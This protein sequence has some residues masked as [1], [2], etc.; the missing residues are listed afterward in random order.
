MRTCGDTP[1]ILRDN[2]QISIGDTMLRFVA[3]VGPEEQRPV[4]QKPVGNG[5]IICQLVNNRNSPKHGSEESFFGDGDAGDR[6]IKRKLPVP[7]ASLELGNKILTAAGARA[8]LPESHLATLR[9]TDGSWYFMDKVA[10]TLGRRAKLGQ[11][12]ADCMVDQCGKSVPRKFARIEFNADDVDGDYFTIEGLGRTAIVVNRETY[13]PK[14]LVVLDSWSTIDIGPVQ[15]EFVIAGDPVEHNAALTIQTMFRRCLLANQLEREAGRDFSARGSQAERRI[16]G[17]AAMNT[18]ALQM[19]LVDAKRRAAEELQRLH[20]AQTEY[21]LIMQQHANPATES[22]AGGTLA[23]LWERPERGTVEIETQNGELYSYD[24]Q[25]GQT[26]HLSPHSRLSKDE[27]ATAIQARWRGGVIR[28]WVT[29]SVVDKWIAAEVIQERYRGHVETRKA[30][31]TAK[32]KREE[33]THA[34]MIQKI[35]RGRQVRASGMGLTTRQSTNATDSSRKNAAANEL[36]HARNVV[37]ATLDGSSTMVPKFRRLALNRQ[38][39]RRALFVSRPTFAPNLPTAISGGSSKEDLRYSELRGSKTAVRKRRAWVAGV[40]EVD[41]GNAD[42]VDEPKA[43]LIVLTL[44]AETSMDV[45][46]THGSTRSLDFDSEIKAPWSMDAVSPCRFD[47]SVDPHMRTNKDSLVSSNAVPGGVA[48]AHVVALQ[49]FWR[50]T[51]QRMGS[52]REFAVEFDRFE[53]D[54][55]ATYIQAWA[56]GYLARLGAA[57][58]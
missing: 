17:M 9:G 24:P 22:T 51:L 19:R 28:E 50:G 45:S 48:E 30:Q 49:R 2:D 58:I 38:Q 4:Q 54:F 34:T 40:S 56:R 31:A 23:A 7:M 39:I 11:N 43:S 5:S 42:D 36:I 35:W 41:L 37:D 44:S 12:S 3:S 8:L 6:F 16:V 26:T 55:C 53:V 25:T 57:G 33:T 1:Y 47:P 52:S 13:Q 27:A 32:R 15:L 29:A 20:K 10:I 18:S 21:E 14:E 46:P